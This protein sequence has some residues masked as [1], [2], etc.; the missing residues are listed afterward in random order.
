MNLIER[1]KAIILSPATEWPVIERESGEPAYLFM[2]YV[3]ILALI[4]A[5][6]GFIG[7]S[8]IGV[9]VPVIGTVRVPFFTGL[10]SA[11]F[12]YVLTFVV[13]YVVGLIVDLLAPTFAGQKN[14]ANALKLAVYSF[15]PAWL[16]GIFQIIPG[17]A[18]LS[19]LG[20]YGIYLFWLG[21]PILMKAPK[22]K[23]LV[24]TIAVVVCA[25]VVQIVAVAIVSAFVA[26]PG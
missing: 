1:A 26:F 2:N 7:T 20:L 21:L 18:F 25:I 11:I 5:I 3:A 6:A 10:F 22:D 9:S 16:A 12:G 24:Y 14:S 4:P 17:L 19:I 13:V 23:A 8:I 15:T